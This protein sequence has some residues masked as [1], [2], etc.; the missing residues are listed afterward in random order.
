[1]RGVA[2]DIGVGKAARINNGRCQ[3]GDSGIASSSLI[4]TIHN[5]CVPSGRIACC[6]SKARVSL[7]TLWSPWYHRVRPFLR[8]MISFVD[9]SASAP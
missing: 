8:R 9:G 5:G 4:L 3:L 1:M 7:K 6:D 2:A